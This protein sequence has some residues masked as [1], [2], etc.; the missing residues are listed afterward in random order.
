MVKIVKVL[1]IPNIKKEVEKWNEENGKE[2][3]DKPSNRKI[4][5]S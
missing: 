5:K 2:K 3:K 1:K 4:K